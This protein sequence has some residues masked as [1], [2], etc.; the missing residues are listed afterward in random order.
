[1]NP[2]TLTVATAEAL[3]VMANLEQVLAIFL[4]L[5]AALQGLVTWVVRR[6]SKSEVKA[7]DDRVD[8]VEGRVKGL[9]DDL[10]RFAE[11]LPT[12]EDL[13]AL[14]LELMEST[15]DLKTA[16]EVIHTNQQSFEQR[17]REAQAYTDQQIKHTERLVSRTEKAA[18]ML[19][20]HLLNR[21]Q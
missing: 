13:H 12:R 17:V 8:E 9:A 16:T 5:S 6:A 21:G 14:R 7:V 15:Q 18:D 1:M 19:T 4:I 2:D 10:K 20:E 11:G 3:D